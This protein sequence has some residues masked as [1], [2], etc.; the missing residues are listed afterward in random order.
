LS[1]GEQP[2]LDAADLGRSAES[3]RPAV[4]LPL[5]HKMP[6]C[7]AALRKCHAKAHRRR[8]NG[9]RSGVLHGHCRL[10]AQPRG[11]TR[12]I[13]KSGHRFF[14]KIMRKNKEGENAA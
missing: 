1:I 7:G 14:E 10:W 8:Y 4:G 3:D 2:N 5:P 6:V 11:F 13:R 12:M 9:P